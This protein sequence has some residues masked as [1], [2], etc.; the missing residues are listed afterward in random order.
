[1]NFYTYILFSESAQRFYTGSCNVLKK[2]FDRHNRSNVP[3][4][5]HG[6]PWTLVWSHELSSRSEAQQL[7]K[8]IKKRGASRFLNDLKMSG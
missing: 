4:T 3:S 7:E 6:V 2:R 8:K 1:M 5:K